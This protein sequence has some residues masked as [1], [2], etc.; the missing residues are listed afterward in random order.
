MFDVCIIIVMQGIVIFVM[1][2]LVI[3]DGKVVDQVVS[4]VCCSDVKIVVICDDQWM[5]GFIG[6][7]IIVVMIVCL[8]EQGVLMWD[9]LLL[10][11]LLELLVQMC[12]EYCNVIL[13]QLLLY[14][15][16]LL[17]NLI[18]VVVL[19]VFFIDVWLLLVQ[20]EVYIKVVLVDVLV[21]VL[22]IEFVYSNSGFLIVVVI[23]EYVIGKDVEM[24]MQCEVFDLLG[25][26]GVG[27]GLM[28]GN[29]LLGY[30]VGKLVIIVLCKVDDGV[31]L[32]YIVVGNLYMC[33]QDLVLFVIDQFVGSQGKGMLLIL[34]FYVLMQIV[35]LGSGLGL[36]W[37]VQLF[38]VGCQGF[39]FVYGG[40]D[41]NWLVW[42]VL[43]FGQNNVVIVIVNVVEDMG[44]DKV[45]M[46]VLG[47]LFVE[48]V[49]LL[50]VFVVRQNGVGCG[51]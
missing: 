28:C 45:M 40:L 34:V 24:L 51:L 3:C 48:L 46:G 44:V 41:G 8:V 21:Y 17:E 1:G 38:I 16:G 19:D 25:M 30:C 14:C 39:V 49:L 47:G 4:G 2:V 43:F 6:K 10:M 31:L 18:D 37:G 12:L 32:I 9:V 33:L 13:V 35:Q 22:G 11:M 27:F 29:Q 23:V 5:I 36:D 20:C 50:V 42:V 15:V 26:M 7:L